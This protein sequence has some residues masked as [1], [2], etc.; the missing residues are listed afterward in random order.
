MSYIPPAYTDAGGNLTGGYAPPAYTAAGG[1]VNPPAPP[2]GLESDPTLYGDVALPSGYVLL[3]EF[4]FEGGSYVQ[5][6][7]TDW[8]YSRSTDSIGV[9]EFQARIVEEPSY[10]VRLGCI[11]WG[12]KTSV[13][14]GDIRVADPNSDLDW[15]TRGHRDSLVVLRLAQPYGAYD[16]A[17]V[18]GKAIVD[19]IDADDGYKS[20]KLRGIDTLLDK[21]LQSTVFTPTAPSELLVPPTSEGVYDFT[22]PNDG[23]TSNATLEG[24]KIPVVVGKVWQNEPPLVSPQ[25]LGFQIT[26]V[27][28]MEIME[29]LSGGSEALSPQSSTD[30]DWDYAYGDSGFVMNVSPSARVTVNCDG[31]KA[32]SAPTFNSNLDDSTEWSGGAPIGWTTT[33]DGS[34][35]YVEFA[36]ALFDGPV[37]ISRSTGY[38]NGTWALVII[39]IGEITNGTVTVSLGGDYIFSRPGRHSVITYVTDSDLLE[40]SGSADAYAYIHDIHAYEFINTSTS[41]LLELMRH[42]V[43]ARGALPDAEAIITNVIDSSDGDFNTASDLDPLEQEI[44]GDATITVNGG[45]LEMTAAAASDGLGA[46]ARVAWPN[47]LQAGQRYTFTIDINITSVSGRPP[48]LGLYPYAGVQLFFRPDSLTYTSYIRLALPFTVGTHSFSGS[49]TPTEAGKLVV[50]TVAGGQESIS[51]TIDNVTL[52]TVEFS[53]AGSTV[54]FESLTDIDDG[55]TYGF[56]MDGPQTVREAMTRALDSIGGWFYPDREGRIRFGQIDVPSGAANIIIDNSNMLGLP[57]AVQDLA[58]GLSDT[59]GA[60]KNWSPYSDSELAGITYP[61]RPPYRAEYRAVKRG[62]SA[63]TLARPYTHAV[64]AEAIASFI[65]DPDDAQTEIN[66]LTALYT[67][68]QRFWEVEVALESSVAA[69]S[70][71]PDMNAYLD[72]EFFG[73]DQG[74]L[75]KIVGVAGRYRSQEVVL[76]LWAPT[77]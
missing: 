73:S 25:N 50:E 44:V 29:V 65:Y 36:G 18:V 38:T 54:D 77:A 52:S 22:N 35:S 13:S 64:G 47:A 48:F 55:Y 49:F 30:P 42:V 37:R 20:V 72:S 60:A 7:A 6:V 28:I 74:K 9:R 76:T 39:N 23:Q 45:V 31:A 5:R 62:A 68:Q 57:R 19:S 33:T 67:T 4:Y 15:M 34:L 75:A 43:V 2:S 63:E 12:R 1:D 41:S 53:D 24:V 16:D 17:I 3:A 71:R 14:V 59:I 11:L 26:D 21:P 58:T 51:A 46:A 10:G 40:V 61:D 69:A 27:G 56:V 32:L 66:R 8:W 70:L